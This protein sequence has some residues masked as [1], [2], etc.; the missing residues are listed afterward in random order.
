MFHGATE[1]S[2]F[3][4]LVTYTA[5]A[6]LLAARRLCVPVPVLLSIRAV[7]DATLHAVQGLLPLGGAV[8]E[9]HREFPSVGI[10]GRMN[11]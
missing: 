6:L 5:T 7:T 2:P 8:P 11:P 10:Q 3:S 9:E 4:T 1:T